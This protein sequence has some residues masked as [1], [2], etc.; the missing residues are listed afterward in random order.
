MT[1]IESSGERLT[2]TQR[3]AA[4]LR[5]IAHGLQRHRAQLDALAGELPPQAAA[6]ARAL[7]AQAERLVQLTDAAGG[8]F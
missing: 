3:T 6:V 2:P 8:R 7:A 4:A 1:T 5:A